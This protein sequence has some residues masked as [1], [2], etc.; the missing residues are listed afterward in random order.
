MSTR[1]RLSV[2]RLTTRPS[3]DTT[4]RRSLERSRITTRARKAARRQPEACTPLTRTVGARVSGGLVTVVSCDALLLALFESG[5]SEDTDAVFVIVP[6]SVGRTTIVTVADAPFARSPSAHVTVVVPEQLPWLAV[7]D[8]ALN[9]AGSVS[10][11]VTAL[12]VFGPLFVTVSVYVRS[13]PV[14]VGSAESTFVMARS[15]GWTILPPEMTPSAK[16][17]S[18]KLFASRSATFSAVPGSGS[19]KEL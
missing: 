9:P 2:V 14:L 11:T 16:R 7:N 13:R 6:V 8:L 17:V 10:V 18:G 12:D 19:S 3:T 15:A 5:V 4:T 1:N